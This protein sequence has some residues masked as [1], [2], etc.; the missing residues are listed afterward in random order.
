MEA[1]LDKINHLF[2]SRDKA[3][4]SAEAVTLARAASALEKDNL[5][6]NADYLAKCFLGNKYTLYLKFPL[7]CRWLF[8]YV[9]PGGYCY[10][11]ARTK[12]I[13]RTF[14]EV[15]GEDIRQFVILGAGYDSRPYRFREQL[16][17]IKIYELDLPS[18]Q[19]RKKECLIKEFGAIPDRVIYVPIDFN[20]QSIKDVLVEK[21]YKPFEKTFFIWEGVTYYLNTDA[22]NDV[23]DFVAKN[24]KAGSSIIFDYALRSFIE[25]DYSTYGA[26]NLIKIWEK[27]GEPGLSGI[28]DGGI[29]AFLRQKGFDMV[30]DLGPEELEQTYLKR[31]DGTLLGK[32]FGCMRIAHAKVKKCI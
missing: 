27:F 29:E 12:H 21:G 6:R 30:S 7:L 25:G 26:R 2:Q 9:A 32:V 28:E 10:F 16:I 19:S 13:D 31:E 1:G 15:L 8:E 11:N 20:A 22:V 5:A 14:L 18:T 17:N 24:S 23:L 4:S 3:L